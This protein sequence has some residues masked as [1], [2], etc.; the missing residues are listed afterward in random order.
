MRWTHVLL[1][2]IVAILCSSCS[3]DR[4]IHPFKKE[5]KL[6]GDYNACERDI[7]NGMVTNPGVAS[8]YTNVNVETERVNKCL[9]QK[10]W[11][12]IEEKKP[13]AP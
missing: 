12:K 9:Y 3:S 13:A 4:W 8:M 6:T 7:M 11:R 5:D 2:P 10:G 1:M